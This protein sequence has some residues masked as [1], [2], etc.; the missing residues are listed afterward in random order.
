VKQIQI[1]RHPPKPA[2]APAGVPTTNPKIAQTWFPE[3]GE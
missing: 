2:P 1:K 3:E